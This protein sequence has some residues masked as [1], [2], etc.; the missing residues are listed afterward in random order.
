MTPARTVG[1]CRNEA[2]KRNCYQNK[3]FVANWPS[4]AGQQTHKCSLCTQMMDGCLL[5][6]IS[7]NC[8]VNR[9]P[10]SSCRV[11]EYISVGVQLFS[12]CWDKFALAL[13]QFVRAKHL[14][15]PQIS[16]DSLHSNI[17]SGLYIHTYTFV[18]AKLIPDWLC[19]VWAARAVTTHHEYPVG[20]HEWRRGCICSCGQ[21]GNFRDSNL[22]SFMFILPKLGTLKI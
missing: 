14:Q 13:Q 19:L 12:I 2:L 17:T 21:L 11:A 7:D 3:C 15:C 6:I 18:F 1:C 9:M 8:E 16:R 20:T 22:P 4:S 5:D 10:H